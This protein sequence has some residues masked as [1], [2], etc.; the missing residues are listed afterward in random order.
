[1]K[2]IGIAFQGRTFSLKQ[3]S[4][5]RLFLEYFCMKD[6]WLWNSLKSLSLKR[7]GT[8]ALGDGDSGAR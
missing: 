7:C 5:T 1:M 8:Q 6:G 4:R 3:S 2:E